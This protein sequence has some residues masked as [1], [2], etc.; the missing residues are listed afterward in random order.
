MS[1]FSGEKASNVR[2]GGTPSFAQVTATTATAGS[3][4]L[5]ANPLGFINVA[6]EIPG[7][8]RQTLVKI[9]Y[10]SV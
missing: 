10:Y 2:L 3:A 5:P 8:N 9:P 4:T 7:Q 1:L 6:I